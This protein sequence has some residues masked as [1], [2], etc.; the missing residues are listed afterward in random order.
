MESFPEAYKLLSASL[1]HTP[2][3]IYLFLPNS[4][5]FHETNPFSL[6][7][8]T[9][10]IILRLLKSQNIYLKCK[11]RQTGE[12]IPKILRY[13]RNVLTWLVVKSNYQNNPL[14]FLY[15]QYVCL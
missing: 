9:Y 7:L 3:L 11:T 14:N 10:L 13:F 8:I 2:P 1:V 5:Q 4:C 12:T 6:A 15:K